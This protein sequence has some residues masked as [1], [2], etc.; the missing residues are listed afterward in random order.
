MAFRFIHTADLHL[1]SPLKTLA[2]RDPDLGATIATATR[3]AFTTIIDACLAERVDALVIAGDLYDGEIRSMATPLFLGAQLRRLHGAGIP[4]FIIR[5][6]HDAM[7]AVTRHLS[8]PEN[9]HVFGAEGGC[10]TLAS[11]RVA[12][13]GV[14]FQTKEAPE[15]LLPRFQ[16]PV[17]GAINIG[18][19]HTS[20]AGAE[21][22]D[23]YAPCAVAD[24]VRH[25]FD[26]WALGH[27]HRRSIHARSPHVVMPGMPQ[28]RDINEAGPKSATLVQIGDDGEIALR[29]IPTAA[30]EFCRLEIDVS[31]AETPDD[32][33]AMLREAM[34]AARAR[35]PVE[36]LVV[37]PM[38]FGRTGL[39]TWMRAD[40]ERLAA[41]AAQAAASVGN[42]LI[43][44]VE[45][46]AKPVETA[47]ETKHHDPLSELQA[48][49][50]TDVPAALVQS[51]ERAIRDMR[52]LLPLD[53][54]DRV[55]GGEGSEEDLVRLL[56][57]EGG[58][59]VLARLAIRSER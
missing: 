38:C 29:E 6:N 11:Q 47:P 42:V 39:F 34:A 14:S 37:R 59:D 54:R 9:V 45:N 12:I 1:D 25:G 50:L 32:L 10:V 57:R 31:P 21:G 53:V 16:R 5:G 51:A 18:M 3:R 26:Y 19:L 49:V 35:S 15:S 23:T 13:H 7:A 52:Q 27:V 20:L 33:A 46:R 2:L 17:P 41:E 43:D 24:L 4:V 58:E 36:T 44:V 8:L 55:F 56:I 30:A 22:H 28:G 40:A 48:L